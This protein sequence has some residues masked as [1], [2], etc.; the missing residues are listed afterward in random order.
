[1][2]A[3]RLVGGSAAIL[4]ALASTSC[5]S[6]RDLRSYEVQTLVAVADS[7]LLDSVGPLLRPF[8]SLTDS[9]S[10][11]SYFQ[12]SL[13]RGVNV[14]YGRV[15]EHGRTRG[16]FRGAW[17]RYGFSHPDYDWL[18]GSVDVR[19]D[20]T[21]RPYGVGNLHFVPEP[22][23]RGEPV[24]FISE[25]EALAIAE[26]DGLLPG[27]SEPTARLRYDRHRSSYVWTVTRELSRE[28]CVCSKDYGTLDIVEIDPSSGEVLGHRERV[29]M[30]NC[31]FTSDG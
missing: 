7:V 5:T 15:S 8:F 25:R 18:V 6:T 23:L 26:R 12:G 24:E 2:M 11:Y 22:V 9:T 20:S 29:F 30:S 28:C 3:R 10:S 27:I 16:D 31:S 14:R 21:L 4:L 13:S 19:L 17:V 1:M